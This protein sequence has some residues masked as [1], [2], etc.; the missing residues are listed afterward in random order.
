MKF[1]NVFYSLEFLYKV[2]VVWRLTLS[3]HI[4]RYITMANSKEEVHFAN[5]I[6]AD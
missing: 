4:L 5:I 6:T 2:N 3:M 1:L